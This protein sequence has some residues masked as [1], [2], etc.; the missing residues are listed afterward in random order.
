[1]GLARRAV[2][3]W[4][5]FVLRFA[6]CLSLWL[7]VAPLVTSYVYLILMHR[8]FSC[9]FERWNRDLLPSDTVSGA[10]LA[11][12]ILI[13]FLSLMSFA[14]FLRVEWQQQHRLDPQEPDAGHRLVREVVEAAEDNR[15]RQNQ[16]NNAII[17]Q[18]NQ[19]RALREAQRNAENDGAD[20]DEQFRN[21]RTLPDQGDSQAENREDRGNRIDANNHVGNE[22]AHVR[23]VGNLDNA[24]PIENLNADFRQ[25]PVDVMPQQRQVPRVDPRDDRQM[26][27]N[28]NLDPL[29]QDD[30]V[31]SITKR[32]LP[33]RV[34]RTHRRHFFSIGRIWK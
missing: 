26:D 7:V 12:I 6:F 1:M 21:A 18:I 10:V 30:Q 11:A 5:P 25:R 31:V 23:N 3:R 29:L 20:H 33:H 19:Q 17:L 4:L 13:S 9:I 8:S 32:Y 22:N 2:A 27:A 24:A 15:R 14:D 34:N 28:M 16:V